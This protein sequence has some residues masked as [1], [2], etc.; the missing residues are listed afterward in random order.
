[1]HQCTNIQQQPANLVTTGHY[2]LPGLPGI[3]NSRGNE[4]I[5]F[6]DLPFISS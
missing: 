6:S 4:K 2:L 3:R 5:I 1:M